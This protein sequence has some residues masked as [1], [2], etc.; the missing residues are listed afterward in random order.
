MI[1]KF[2]EKGVIFETL[3][4][5]VLQENSDFPITIGQEKLHLFYY[6]MSAINSCIK[7][8]RED[9]NLSASVSKHVFNYDLSVIESAIVNRL[10]NPLACQFLYS[11]PI[12]F[13]RH[14][15]PSEGRSSPFATYDFDS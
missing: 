13:N 9:R 14:T 15:N 11:L 1:C 2:I 4:I 12:F 7:S 10:A 6:L 3:L 5:I 8:T